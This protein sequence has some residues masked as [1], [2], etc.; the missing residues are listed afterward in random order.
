MR[1][2]QA[3]TGL[4]INVVSR[5]LNNCKTKEWIEVLFSGKAGKRVVSHYVD[6]RK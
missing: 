4:E 2:V 3:V 5:S 6:I 1:Q